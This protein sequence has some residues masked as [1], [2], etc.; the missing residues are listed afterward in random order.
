MGLLQQLHGGDAALVRVRKVFPQATV[1]L[2]ASGR[3]RHRE[4][5]LD[6]TNC[7]TPLG[8]RADTGHRLSNWTQ[9][10]PKRSQ[11]H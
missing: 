10:Q 2:A 3:L 4:T 5:E 6:P 7:E 1:L 11:R 8:D 9:A